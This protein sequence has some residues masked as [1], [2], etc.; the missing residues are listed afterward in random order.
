[1]TCFG[2]EAEAPVSSSAKNILLLAVEDEGLIALG[3]TEKAATV[4]E[5]RH[6][7]DK[8]ARAEIF[9]IDRTIW[10]WVVQLFVWCCFVL[11]G[12]GM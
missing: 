6:V 2:A 7:A 12:S 5:H 1:V 8:K 9:M 4:D 11:C 10:E 3:S